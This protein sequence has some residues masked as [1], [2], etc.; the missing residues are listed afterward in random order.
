MKSSGVSARSSIVCVDQS[1]TIYG[2]SSPGQPRAYS[3]FGHCGRLGA[4]ISLAFNG[5]IWDQ[6]LQGYLLGHGHRFYN[7]TLMRFY[8]ADGFSPFG[9]G[10]INAYAYCAGDPVNNTDPTGKTKIP[11]RTVQTR[12]RPTIKGGARKI[13]KLFNRIRFGEGANLSFEGIELA[14]DKSV[15]RRAMA[16]NN[17]SDVVSGVYSEDMDKFLG[18]NEQFRE[19]L[20]GALLANASALEDDVNSS[21]LDISA[22][23]RTGLYPQDARRLKKLYDAAP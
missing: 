1:N 14:K 8:S 6:K 2:G 18:N 16:H 12:G 3:V 5:E 21:G 23:I 11:V 17:Y 10:G 9:K 22:R 13:S 4:D 15:L 7:P 19:Q 20:H